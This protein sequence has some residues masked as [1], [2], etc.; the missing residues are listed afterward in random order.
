MTVVET[1]NMIQT[2]LMDE[3]A[4]CQEMIEALQKS[5]ADCPKGKLSVREKVN[6]KSLKIYHYYS[7][8]FR[9]KNKVFNLH[10]SESKLPEIQN[11]LEKRMKLIEETKPYKNRIRYI[12]KI[13]GIS[14]NK[15]S[16]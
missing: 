1:D 16:C 5:I 13:L 3:Y 7:L 15:H 2:I 14:R 6:K 4:H 8:K 11:L 12:E 10:I 9:E